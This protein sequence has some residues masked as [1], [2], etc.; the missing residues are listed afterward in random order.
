MIHSS[1]T[2]VWT[3]GRGEANS[4]SIDRL[5]CSGKGVPGGLRYACLSVCLSESVR[6]PLLS[7]YKQGG[8]HN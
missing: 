3:G 7:I 1:E 8:N 2:H 4:V 6:L 5:L